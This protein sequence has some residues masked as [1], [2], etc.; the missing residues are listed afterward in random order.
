[1]KLR[2]VLNVFERKS[3]GTSGRFSDFFLHAPFEKKIKIFTEVAR[4]SNEEQ[5]EVFRESILKPDPVSK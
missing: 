2:A 4:K 5:L 1:M 3:A